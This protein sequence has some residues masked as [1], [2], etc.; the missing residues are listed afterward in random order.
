MK[1]R[2]EGSEEQL[3]CTVVPHTVMREHYPSMETSLLGTQKSV[4]LIVC[5]VVV[6]SLGFD[7]S[8]QSVRSETTT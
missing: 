4:H 6:V 1:L 8:P 5:T 3:S 2:E 7:L